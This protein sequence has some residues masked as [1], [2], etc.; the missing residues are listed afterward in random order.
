[1]TN[2]FSLQFTEYFVLKPAFLSY[3]HFVITRLEL[4]IQG[5]FFWFVFIF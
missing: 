3:V 5:D 1:M 2:G 4:N